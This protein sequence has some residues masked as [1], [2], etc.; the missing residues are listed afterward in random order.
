MVGLRAVRGM[1]TKQAG[2]MGIARR[3]GRVGA[4]G[5]PESGAPASLRLLTP[6][7]GRREGAGQ[8]EPAG[9]LGRVDWAIAPRQ[10]CRAG[11]R[12]ADVDGRSPRR[13]RGRTRREA[14]V[15]VGGTELPRR[16]SPGVGH[17]LLVRSGSSVLRCIVAE[18]NADAAPL[19][20]GTRRGRSITAVFGSAF[21]QE[22][23]P[24]PPCNG[25]LPRRGP[26]PNA[27]ANFHPAGCRK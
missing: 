23:Q 1:V 8:G 5:C 19:G 25:R 21:A 6:P 20:S 15:S 9:N 3:S 18:A 12:G 22:R 4:G 17:E 2:V 27:S 24:N 16:R 10:V 13:T 7:S 26:R 14:E 11:P